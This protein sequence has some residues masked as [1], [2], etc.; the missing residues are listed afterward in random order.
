MLKGL[1]FF[2]LDGTLL[3]E[4]SDV[5][6]TEIKAVKQL[7]ENGYMPIIASGRTVIEIEDILEKTGINSIISMNG[8]HGIFDNEIIFHKQIDNN[9][10]INLKQMV[11][12]R[13]EELAFYNN[14]KIRI[15]GH[16]DMAKKCFERIRSDVPPIDGEMYI[17]DPVYM[18]LVLCNIGDEEYKEAFPE[19]EFVRNGPY[20]IDVFSKGSSK[21]TGIKTLMEKLQ[22]QQIPTYAFGDG[23]NDLEMFDLVDYPVAMGNAVEELKEKASYVTETNLNNGIVQGLRHY[24]LI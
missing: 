19:L 4:Y 17:K 15:T 1:V 22:L 23:L 11:L 12:S 7:Q 9:I 5:G 21:A 10:L 18:A 6:E 8:Q 3:N 14:E 16:D 13:D 20:S 24:H 2:D